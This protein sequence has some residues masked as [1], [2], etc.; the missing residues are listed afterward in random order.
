MCEMKQKTHQEQ[1]NML[2]AYLQENM[3]LI[4]LEDLTPGKELGTYL[5]TVERKQDAQADA[6]PFSYIILKAL[7]EPRKTVYARL[8]RQ[9]NP[10]LETV[11]EQ[12]QVG[13]QTYSVNECIQTPK[14]Y[15][16][17]WNQ[18]SLSLQELVSL[19]HAANGTCRPFTQQEGLI[20]LYQICEGLKSLHRQNLFHGDLSANNILLTDGKV[21]DPHFSKIPGIHHQVM[22]KVIDFGNTK[23]NKLQNHPVT[24]VIGT[25]DF[26]APEIMDFQRPVNQRADIYSLGCLLGYMLTGLSPK[27]ENLQPLV[28][29]AIWKLIKQCT[30]PYDERYRD[31]EQLEKAILRVLNDV[32]APA[33][34][35]LRHIP[36]FRSRNPL[37]MAI[38]GYCYVAMLLSLIIA[39]TLGQ[40]YNLLLTVGFLLCAVAAIFDVFHLTERC[41]EHI[42]FLRKHQRTTLFLRIILTLVFLSFLIWG[43][44]QLY[45]T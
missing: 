27:Q 29:P 11:Y 35:V 25:L 36:G 24:S 23:G 21:V 16:G 19:Q 34:T 7:D 10:Y 5:A 37:K 18:V 8:T 44:G 40:G 39:T 6:L 33:G 13:Q 28:S 14:V 22:C 1:R 41:K 4:G 26:A 45:Q 42:Y 17:V 9:N 3:S 43:V 38:A 30:A 12:I 2:E 31:V 20:F 32:L 15:S